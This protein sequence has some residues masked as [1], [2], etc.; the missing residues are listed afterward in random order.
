MQIYTA[1]GASA[2]SPTAFVTPVGADKPVGSPQTGLAG[3]APGTWS[4]EMIVALAVNPF[5]VIVLLAVVAVAVGL[6]I[7][8]R[9]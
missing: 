7:S 4:S 8:R 6:A 3:R 1:A 5:F 2:P 9:G